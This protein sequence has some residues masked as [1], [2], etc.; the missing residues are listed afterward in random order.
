MK[1]LAAGAAIAIC[2]GLSAC[3]GSAG[4]NGVSRSE[5]FGRD[6]DYVKID[7]VTQWAHQRGATVVVAGRREPEGQETVALVQAAGGDGLFV[8][9]DVGVEAEV[10]AA[11]G[12][13]VSRFG[14][15]DFAANCAGV[16]PTGP[17]VELTEAD[18][19]AAFGTNVKGLFFCLKHEI[20]AMRAIG[21]TSGGAIVTVGSISASM[22]SR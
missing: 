19:E 3:A 18:Y 2:L 9:T 12:L 16:D 14:R 7:A 6:V 13:A 15:L 1:A 5:P 21:Q 4:P 17:L 22:L 20:R 8:R 10:A 11:V